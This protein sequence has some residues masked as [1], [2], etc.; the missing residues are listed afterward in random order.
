MDFVR[1]FVTGGSCDGG[2]AL[3]QFVNTADKTGAQRV[4]YTQFKFH[5]FPHIL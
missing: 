1:D 3:S 2:N 4:S 5:F